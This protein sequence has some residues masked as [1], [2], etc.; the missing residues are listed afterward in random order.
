MSRRTHPQFSIEHV[1]SSVNGDSS[2]NEADFDTIF[3][4]IQPPP[5]FV[6]LQ[7]FYSLLRIVD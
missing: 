7:A 1:C 5:M 4:K 3:E 6:A 2:G